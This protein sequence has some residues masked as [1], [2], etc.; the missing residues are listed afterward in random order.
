V[1]FVDVALLRTLAPVISELRPG[2][3]K[4]ALANAPVNPLPVEVV[5]RPKTGFGVPTMSWLNAMVTR[6][7][8]GCG[9]QLPKTQGLASRQW[10]RI[11]LAGWPNGELWAA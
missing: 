1:P 2:V 9:N 8:S 3:G 11:A 7:Q 4:A 10:A 5:N 6:S